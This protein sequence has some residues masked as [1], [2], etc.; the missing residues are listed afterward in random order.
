MKALH[1]IDPPT[2]DCDW[3][4]KP[5]W[6]ILR[7]IA[8][9]HLSL[10]YC[11]NEKLN[12]SIEILQDL[13]K[14]LNNLEQYPS[15]SKILYHIYASLGL[16]YYRMEEFVNT[17]LFLEKGII[18]LEKFVNIYKE[19]PKEKELYDIYEEELKGIEYIKLINLYLNYK[20]CKISFKLK[21]KAASFK[22]LYKAFG[23]LEQYKEKLKF[24]ED[25][26]SIIEYIRGKLLMVKNWLQIDLR[27][28]LLLDLD[29]QIKE[30]ERE[31]IS[32]IFDLE[33]ENEEK[34]NKNQK[35][36]TIEEPKVY[37]KFLS[38][39]YRLSL[40][41]FRKN[42][43]IPLKPIQNLKKKL[44]KPFSIAFVVQ[45]PRFQTKSP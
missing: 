23:L 18:N 33:E 4:S 3:E 19:K 38:L 41:F 6:Q 26:E 34:H 37:L 14:L 10:F 9:S 2:K 13:S 20:I 31:E 8:G 42:K 35:N 21:Q 22:S 44:K 32:D 28:G 7:I 11:K 45:N 17:R 36:W 27:K 24:V 12:K 40:F 5:E 30:A 25:S 43:K 15:A 29:Q 1:V 16:L 39:F